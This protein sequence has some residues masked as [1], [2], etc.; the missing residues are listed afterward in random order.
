VAPPSIMSDNAIAEPAFALVC[1][2]RWNPCDRE[3]HVFGYKDM[4]EDMGPCDA[5]CP[6]RILSLLGAGTTGWS[7]R[8]SSEL[9]GPVGCHQLAPGTNRLQCAGSSGATGTAVLWNARLPGTLSAGS[10]PI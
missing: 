1:L 7:S 10:I 9:S 4:S 5:E 3:G 8:P 2:V 6:E